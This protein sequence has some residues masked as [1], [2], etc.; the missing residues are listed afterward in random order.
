MMIGSEY[1]GRWIK[2]K[3]DP[4]TDGRWVCEYTIVEFRPTGLFSESGYPAGSFTVRDEAE[5]AA[6]AAA[7]GIIDA[8]DTVGNPI[9]EATRGI[10]RRRSRNRKALSLSNSL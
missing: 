4:Q 3:T 6:L 2:V 7:Q 5:T 1:E 10:V 8:R 9:T